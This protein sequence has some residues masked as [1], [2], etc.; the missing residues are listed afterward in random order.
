MTPRIRSGNPG[1]DG[2]LGGGLAADSITLICG[3]PGSGKT[4]LAEQYVFENASTERPA[5]Y[6]STVSEPH[7]KLLRYGQTLDFFDVGRIGHDVFYEDLGTPLVNEGLPGV[8][9][10]IDGVLKDIRPGLLVIDSFK[11]LAAFAT[12]EADYRRFLHEVAGR[13]TATAVSRHLDRGVRPGR[14]DPLPGVRGGGRRP[15]PD[16]AA[17]GSS[18]RCGSCRC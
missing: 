18:G 6:L 2:I 15:Q 14:L 11:A 12:S 10:A 7:E 4:I 16:H 1:L 13:L 3:P 8:V 5:L 9:A 17:A